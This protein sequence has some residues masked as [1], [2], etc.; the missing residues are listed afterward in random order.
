M[1]KERTNWP[2]LKQTATAKMEGTRKSKRPRERWKD[3]VEKNLYIM[4]IKNSKAMFIDG[5]KWRKVDFETKLHTGLQRLRRRRKKERKKEVR[6]PDCDIRCPYWACWWGWPAE[7]LAGST[8]VRLCFWWPDGHP[9]GRRN[10]KWISTSTVACHCDAYGASWIP[11][12]P[13][14][15]WS[16][17]HCRLAHC[18]ST[19]PPGCG[20]TGGQHPVR[21]PG[22]PNL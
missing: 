11:L 20:T 6:I 17:H 5:R 7:F 10:N 2:M 12:P 22:R 4:G 3:D 8:C 14:V 18:N 13:P 19:L 15:S 9:W 16:S 21:L 1:W